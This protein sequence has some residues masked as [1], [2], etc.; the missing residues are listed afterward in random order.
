VRTDFLVR[1]KRIGSGTR[2]PF[3]TTVKKVRGRAQVRARAF[4]SDGREVTR[5]KVLRCR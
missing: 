4:L 5:D 3:A 2:A 1:G